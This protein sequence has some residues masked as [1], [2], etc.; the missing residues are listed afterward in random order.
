M[1]G[2]NSRKQMVSQEVMVEIRNDV[3][4]DEGGHSENMTRKTENVC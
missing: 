3:G 2:N 1:E 4:L